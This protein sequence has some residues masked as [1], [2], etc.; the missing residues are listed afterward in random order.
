MSD[1][2][3]KSNEKRAG[4]KLANVAPVYLAYPPPFSSNV[5]PSISQQGPIGP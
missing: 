2:E 1:R 4:G 5:R 3:A